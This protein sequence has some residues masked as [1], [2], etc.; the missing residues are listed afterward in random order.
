MRGSDVVRLVSVRGSMS[1]ALTLGGGAAALFTGG[2]RLTRD[3][4]T[5]SLNSSEEFLGDWITLLTRGCFGCIDLG[6]PLVIPTLIGVT[7]FC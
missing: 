1:S 4:C 3:F 7:L 5:D 2:S 6:K